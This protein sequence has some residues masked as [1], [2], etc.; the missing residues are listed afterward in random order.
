VLTRL[1]RLGNL[2]GLLEVTVWRAYGAGPGTSPFGVGGTRYVCKVVLKR[3][4]PDSAPP[5]S[6]DTASSR[7][8]SWP[9]YFSPSR[10]LPPRRQSSVSSR[11]APLTPM[12]TPLLA[13]MVPN[14]GRSHTCQCRQLRQ[15]QNSA[16]N[17][18]SRHPHS[19][20]WSA[21]ARAAPY[22]GRSALL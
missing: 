5:R 11:S 12:P 15:Q 2:P 16:P 18:V 17:K 20:I 9:G 4:T 6:D 8:M 21:L 7:S 14:A 3:G 13:L 19:Y 10:N 22:C 1:Q